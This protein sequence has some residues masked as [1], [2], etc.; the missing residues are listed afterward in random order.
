MYRLI[1]NLWRK[2]HKNSILDFVC[3]LSCDQ[4]CAIVSSCEAVLLNKF[5]LLIRILFQ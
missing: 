5:C 4:Y 1:S 2:C 3:D